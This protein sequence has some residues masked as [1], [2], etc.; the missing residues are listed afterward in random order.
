MSS[1]SMRHASIA[2]SNASAGELAA[3]TG[4]GV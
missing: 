1:V 2:L 4:S 3:L